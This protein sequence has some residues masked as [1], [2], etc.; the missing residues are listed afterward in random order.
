MNA[1]YIFRQLNCFKCVYNK[2]FW[3]D[4]KYNFT[5]F[6]NLKRYCFLIIYK[7]SFWNY[8]ILIFLSSYASGFRNTQVRLLLFFFF[9]LSSK[10]IFLFHF[11]K[12][13]LLELC[14]THHKTLNSPPETI[15]NVP[16]LYKREVPLRYKRVY[17]CHLTSRWIQIPNI[18]RMIKGEAKKELNKK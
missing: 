4:K 7:N 2:L 5:K 1:W 11:I 17:R 8:V 3:N 6:H 15:K 16:Y 14:E 12:L 18:F 13:S 9:I 10:K